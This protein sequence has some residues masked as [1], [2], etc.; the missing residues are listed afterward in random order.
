MAL[1]NLL[2]Q[3]SSEF[4]MILVLHAGFVVLQARIQTIKLNHRNLGCHQIQWKVKSMSFSI[5]ICSLHFFCNFQGITN[6]SLTA[7]TI[8]VLGN[9][10]CTLDGSYIVNSDPSILDKL[11][12]CPDLTASQAAAVETLLISGKTK[13]GYVESSNTAKQQNKKKLFVM[14]PYQQISIQ[15][16]V[17]VLTN[18]SSCKV[19]WTNSEGPWDVTSLFV[20]SLLWQF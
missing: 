11:N 13:Y 20:F 4:H 2:K 6:T 10:C 3:W 18:Q 15:C 17:F 8:S 5:L 12:N 1:Y 16:F 19:E 7:D 9:M 14:F